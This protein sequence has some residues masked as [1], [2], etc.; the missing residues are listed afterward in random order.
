MFKNKKDT[1][2][3]FFANLDCYNLAPI[4]NGYLYILYSIP[5]PTKT[6]LLAAK[7]FTLKIFIAA[8][9]FCLL[10]VFGMLLFSRK[11]SSAIVW[12]LVSSPPPFHS[13]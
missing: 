9:N 11:M 4:S 8:I 13:S 6:T 1:T 2:I 5:Y 12:L 7:T 3:I 10:A